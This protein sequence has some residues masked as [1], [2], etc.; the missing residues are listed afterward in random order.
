MTM[1]GRIAPIVLGFWDSQLLT[2]TIVTKSYPV[3]A[4]FSGSQADRFHGC[5]LFEAHWMWFTVVSDYSLELGLLSTKCLH[6]A[7]T[8]SSQSNRLKI[9]EGL[10]PS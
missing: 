3:P 10:S 1:T 2:L 8:G 7:V 9:K 4:T 5:S 6:L